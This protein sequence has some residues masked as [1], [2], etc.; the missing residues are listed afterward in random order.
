MYSS[1]LLRYIGFLLLLQQWPV[2]SDDD[3]VIH[4][5]FVGMLRRRS[6]CHLRF[7]FAVGLVCFQVVCVRGGNFF[8]IV[9]FSVWLYF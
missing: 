3:V 5:S 9:C 4:F 2:R 7:F 8:A 1:R 6:C